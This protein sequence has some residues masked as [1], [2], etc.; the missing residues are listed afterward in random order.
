[1]NNLFEKLKMAIASNK[2]IQQD[3]QNELQNAADSFGNGPITLA[4]PQQASILNNELQ[5][6]NEKFGGDN[7]F[8]LPSVAQNKQSNL[9]EKLKD[10][11]FGQ[12]ITSDINS[13]V[14][15]DENGN[16]IL[17]TGASNDLRQ[18]GFLPDVIGG[19]RENFNNKFELG[20]LEDSLTP[21]GRRKGFAYRLGE[22]LGSVGRFLESPAGRA[23]IVG[24]L[25]G[26]S[27]GSG[28]EALAYGASA[29][30]G[31]QQN[32]FADKLYRQSLENQGVNTSALPKGY[33]NKDT[34]NTY[35]LNNYR[36]NSL[37]VKQEIANASDNTK[38]AN[39]I[40]TALK[41]GEITPEEA[42]MHMNNYGITFEQLQ[43]SNDTQLLPYKQ[44]ALKTAP[45]VA[46][47]NLGLNQARL[48]E[49]IQQNDFNNAIKLEELQAKKEKLANKEDYKDVQNQLNAFEKT[50]KSA[51]NPYRYRV[52]GKDRGFWNAGGSE[53]WNALTKDEANFNAQRTLLFNQIARKLGGEKGV[54]SDADIKR[55]E[56]ALPSLSDTFEQKKAKMD[57]IYQLLDIKKGDY[58][59]STTTV[60]KY[61]VTVK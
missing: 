58:G 51:N 12:K 54:L 46:L 45:Q 40:M 18:G 44:Y 49:Q 33:L 5:K 9:F 38:R 1:M 17:K 34:Y 20:N 21:D 13:S 7:A 2:L 32:R 50:F 53:G 8:N 4:T 37:A 60:G 26:A 36:N 28:L 48:Q 31:N 6:I 19:A 55:V 41:N 22:G 3:E 29:G 43:Q 25:V 23:L 42:K 57:A 15:N 24:G 59:N 30:V 39:L 61:K 27:G 52:F 56:A 35:A 10:N 16:P 47:G 11:M 14:E